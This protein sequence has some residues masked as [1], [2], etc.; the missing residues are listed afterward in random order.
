MRRSKDS[1]QKKTKNDDLTPD[2]SG[3]SIFT[4]G[5]EILH[6]VQNDN[7]LNRSLGKLGMTGAEIRMLLRE[8]VTK[9]EF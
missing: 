3:S 7:Y 5:I 4:I 9:H 1:P 6:Y 8:D 2:G